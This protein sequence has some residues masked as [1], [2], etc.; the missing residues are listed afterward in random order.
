[1][2]C[3]RW[4]PTVSVGE[5]DVAECITLSLEVSEMF[6]MVIRLSVEVSEMSQM[7]SFCQWGNLIFDIGPNVL[8]DF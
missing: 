3:S 8:L 2:R 4:Y 5:W 1:M 7:V 6:Q